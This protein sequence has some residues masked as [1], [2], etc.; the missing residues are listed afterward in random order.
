MISFQRSNEKQHLVNSIL[1]PQNQKRQAPLRDNNFI[2]FPSAMVLSF[3]LR[4][5]CRHKSI[6]WQIYI[7]CRLIDCKKN[8]KQLGLFSMNGAQCR[9]FGCLCQI[10]FESLATCHTMPMSNPESG[11]CIGAANS[12]ALWKTT[13]R[14]TVCGV[15]LK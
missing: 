7:D 12:S 4:S 5:D 2:L 9:R 8:K 3:C 10:Y 11:R 13:Q 14:S 15:T 1:N 6:I